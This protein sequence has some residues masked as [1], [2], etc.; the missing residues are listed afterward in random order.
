LT[1]EGTEGTEESRDENLKITALGALTEGES[2]SLDQRRHPPAPFIE[3]LAD[4]PE[5]CFTAPLEK[6][7]RNS[8]KKA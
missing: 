7:P 4:S 5:T 6:K 2:L 3:L 8:S 1:T